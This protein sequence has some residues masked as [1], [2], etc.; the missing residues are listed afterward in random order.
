MATMFAPTI[1]NASESRFLFGNFSIAGDEAVFFGAVVFGSG[2]SFDTETGLPVGGMI[3]NIELQT[4]SALEVLETHAS[5][6]DINASVHQLNNAFLNA[7]APW[8]DPA[9]FFD[10]SFLEAVKSGNWVGGTDDDVFTGTDRADDLQDCDGHD[11]LHGANGNDVVAGG[12]DD[13][14]RRSGHSGN[15]TVDGGEG[16]DKIYGSQGNDTLITGHGSDQVSGGAGNDTFVVHLNGDGGQT[17]LRDFTAG[18]DS[19]SF[20]TGDLITAE[21]IMEIFRSSASQ[22]GKHVVFDDAA[23]NRM[24]LLH[25]LL[26]DIPDDAFAVYEDGTEPDVVLEEFLF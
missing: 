9:Q 15:D 22:Q 8:Y 2:L 17:T 16:D 1:T 10:T 14:D 3:S 25:T 21:E 24:T 12:G 5:Y 6:P 23:G 26:D 18:E 13:D 19:L 4:R 7:D 11:A 20:L